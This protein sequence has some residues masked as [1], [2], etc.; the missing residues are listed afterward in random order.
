MIRDPA[1]KLFRSA[2][3][4]S[5][6]RLHW[7]SAKRGGVRGRQACLWPTPWGVPLHERSRA[8]MQA[9]GPEF[10]TMQARGHTC[11][12]WSFSKNARARV[13]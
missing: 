11:G 13:T 3:L 7:R 12:G 10:R 9:S 6:C 4:E 2:H 5:L 1:S 8:G